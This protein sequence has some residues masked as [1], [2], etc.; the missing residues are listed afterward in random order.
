M[1][2]HFNDPVSG[3]TVL[4]L[5]NNQF[6]IV[7]IKKTQIVQSGMTTFHLFDETV[8]ERATTVETINK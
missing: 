6:Q 1:L 5:A 8:R 3:H 7:K 4:A 2:A